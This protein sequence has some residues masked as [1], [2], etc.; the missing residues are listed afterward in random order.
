MLLEDGFQRKKDKSVVII[1]I[2]IIIIIICTYV[3]RA[4]ADRVACK[5]PRRTDAY[6]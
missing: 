5:K 2:N 3:Q 6:K 4:H 1:V